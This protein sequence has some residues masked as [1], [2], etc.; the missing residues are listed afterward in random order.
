MLNRFSIQV[1]LANCRFFSII[2]GKLTERP[3]ALVFT[4]SVRRTPQGNSFKK[5]SVGHITDVIGE[6]QLVRNQRQSTRGTE[7]MDFS[8][9]ESSRRAG[10]LALCAVLQHFTAL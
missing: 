4:T 3:H 7:A 6:R 10:L 5:F 8:E 2:S 1:C 9:D